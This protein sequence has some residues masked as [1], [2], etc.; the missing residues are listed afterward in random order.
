MDPMN[1]VADD[2]TAA[3]EAAAERPL[4]ILYHHRI[5]AS[6]GMRV[7]LGELVE[8]LRRQ[9]HVVEVVGPGSEAAPSEVDRGGSRLEKLADLLRKLLPPA[10]F[11]LLELLYN[12]PAYMRLRRAAAAFEPDVIYERYN[13]YLLAGL[14]FA[15][16]RKLPYLLEINSPLAAERSKFGDLSL[17]AVANRCE[18]A[19]WRGADVALPVT[20]VLG[21]AVE[22]KRGRAEGVHVVPNGF[23]FAKRP[24]PAETAAARARI[25][26]PPGALVLGFV[27]FVRAWHGVGWAVDALAALGDHVHLVIV[28][29]GPAR[30]QLEEHARALGVAERVHF[31]GRV[32][33]EQVAA[34]MQS[35]D[36]ALQ[37]AAVEYASPLKLFEYMGLGRAVLAPDQ[38]NIRE[39]LRDGENALL[40]APGDEAAFRAALE[41]LCADP[42]LRRKLGAGAL[43]SVEETP[44]T[45]DHNAARIAAWSR[46]LARAYRSR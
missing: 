9:G 37:T 4:R 23:N 15:R 27:G 32:P 31:T 19:L 22:A 16:R 36:V 7:H 21:R 46:A 10:G 5:A 41:R 38:P 44:L 1:V 6:D 2:L 11:E 26:A 25:P 42:A 45:W 28:G 30:P 14:R 39:I 18:T 20:A 8:A 3:S 35:F 43:A 12:V 17:K 33:H 24:T 29:D 13:L 34:Y 40:F